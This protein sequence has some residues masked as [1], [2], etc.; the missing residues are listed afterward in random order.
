MRGWG[1]CLLCVGLLRA[2]YSAAV[3]PKA[4]IVVGLPRG[5]RG[6]CSD[7]F[8]GV[9]GRDPPLRRTDQTTNARRGINDDH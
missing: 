2:P 5:V 6:S 7:L 3:Q 1:V 9:A 4:P 8:D